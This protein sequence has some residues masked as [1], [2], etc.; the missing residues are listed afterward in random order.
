MEYMLDNLFIRILNMSITAGY[1]ILAVLVIRFL[2]RKAPRKYL[3]ALWLVIAFRLCC[4]VS[5]STDFSLFNLQRFSGSAPVS[6]MGVMEYIPP[7]IRAMEEPQV[8]TGIRSVDHLVNDQL[9]RASALHLGE[10]SLKNLL[11]QNGH[12]RQPVVMFLEIGKYVWIG[13]AAVFLLYFAVSMRRMKRKVRMAV[14]VEDAVWECDDLTTPFAMGILHPRIYLPCHLHGEQ[15]RMI[16]LHEQYHIRRKDHLVK[17]LAFLL[18]SVYWFHPLVWAA[19]FCMCR[20]M[21]MSCDEKVL[22]LLGEGHGKEYSMTLLAFASDVHPGSRMPLAFGEHDVKSRIRHA[23]GF[24]KPAVWASILTVIAVVTV[25]MLVGTNAVKKTEEIKEGNSSETED[26]GNYSEIAKKLYDARNPYLGDAPANG[27]LLEVIAEALPDTIIADTRFTT[28]LQTSDE[29]YGLHLKVEDELEGEPYLYSMAA[30]ATLMLAL[31]D[32]LGLVKWSYWMES[33]TFIQYWR[34]NDALQWCGVDDIKEY[35]SSPEKVQELLDILATHKEDEVLGNEEY[36]TDVSENTE[37]FMEWYADRPYELYENAV[38]LIDYY[39]LSVYDKDR[40]VVL[41]QTE[42]QIVTVYGCHSIRYGQRGITIDYR[43]TPDGD[44]NYN[45]MDLSWGFDDFPVFMADYDED[46]RDEI[47]L[48]M[49]EKKTMET[50][51]EQLIIFETYETGHVEP[52]VFSSVLQQEE[53]NRLVGTAVD[54][55]NHQVHVVRKGSESSIPV[56]TIPYGEDETVTGTDLTGA[57]GFQLGEEIQ[58]Y[59]AVGTK[60]GNSTIVYGNGDEWTERLL[61]FGVHYS[62][63]N[64]PDGTSFTLTGPEVQ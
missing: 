14:R 8:H 50:S 56:L 61:F 19:W 37:E 10:F 35:G 24:Q 16:L 44:S 34:I 49:A 6:D 21:E 40:M 30:P 36:M 32:N 17:V 11:Y 48:V 13:G 58:M 38:T 59:T 4:P 22:E 47:A 15:R 27:R 12:Y 3:Y 39:T 25:L 7:T 55:D 42:D 29:P 23:L 57:V 1:C 31:T 18:L 51:V 62:E 28:A 53:V 5:V 54:S 52:Y 20:D 60:M 46:G 43:V 2:F 41:A 33:G 26:F 63:N 9:P 45:Y 64:S